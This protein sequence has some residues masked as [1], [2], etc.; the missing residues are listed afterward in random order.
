MVANTQTAERSSTTDIFRNAAAHDGVSVAMPVNSPFTLLTGTD[1]KRDGINANVNT[2]AAEGEFSQGTSTAA[3]DSLRRAR[4]RKDK[5][6]KK[7]K[8]PLAFAIASGTKASVNY[9][10]GT[11]FQD[12]ATQNL[13]NNA[14][15]AARF[16]GAAA[17]GMGALGYTMF[18]VQAVGSAAEVRGDINRLRGAGQQA[19]G[20]VIEEGAEA[21]ARNSS[22]AVSEIAEQ[23]AE[24]GGRGILGLIGRA[25]RSLKAMPLV[26]GVVTAGFV[27][28]EVYSLRNTEY[29]DDAL[30]VG[31]A[32]AIGGL[33]G[34]VTGNLAREFALQANGERDILMESDAR[35]LFNTGTEIYNDLRGG[36]QM[37]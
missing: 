27:A 23:A 16:T 15:I 5:A 35:F 12:E 22:R 36:P 3:G 14:R 7:S 17:G 6:D 24:S 11:I 37:G 30:R 1:A 2:P 4:L 32:E 31:A 33:G 19:T 25:A 18:G 21:A 9:V 29:W 34:F 10:E 8:G 13:L 28:Y 20:E 26:G